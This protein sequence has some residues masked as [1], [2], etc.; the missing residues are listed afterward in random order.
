[1]VAEGPS[2]PTQQPVINGRAAHPTVVNNQNFRNPA[3]KQPMPLRRDASR[4]PIPVAAQPVAVQPVQAPKPAPNSSQVSPW[5]KAPANAAAPAVAA[6]PVYTNPVAPQPTARP[7]A[8]AGPLSPADQLIAEA[9][10]LSTVAKTEQ[11]YSRIIETCRR[12]QASQ[13]G[14]ETGKYAN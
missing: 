3:G 4:P 9:H 13:A 6:A 5:N 1:P 14:P 2:R 8:P 11:D 10:T 7:A 12:A